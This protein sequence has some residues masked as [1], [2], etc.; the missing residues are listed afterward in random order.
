MKHSGVYC[1]DF[2][3]QME[4]H[5]LCDFSVVEAKAS[6]KKSKKKSNNKVKINRKQNGI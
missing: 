3:L 2:L 5:D 4:E 6:S 1:V